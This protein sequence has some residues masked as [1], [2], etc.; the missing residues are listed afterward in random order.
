MEGIASLSGEYGAD[1]PPVA[2][3]VVIG[4]ASVI[5]IFLIVDS[6]ILG[7]MFTGSVKG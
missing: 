3:S 7:G 2:A 4:A 6:K 5:A 1:L